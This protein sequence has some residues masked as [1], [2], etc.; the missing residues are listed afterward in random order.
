MKSRTSKERPISE[1][2]YQDLKER[3]SRELLLW[4]RT[5]ATGEPTQRLRSALHGYYVASRCEMPEFDGEQ[6]RKEKRLIALMGLVTGILA[7]LSH[8]ELQYIK[9]RYDSLTERWEEAEINC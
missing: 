5:D 2:E 3:A 6:G 7:F 8:R 1:Q 9:N 4:A